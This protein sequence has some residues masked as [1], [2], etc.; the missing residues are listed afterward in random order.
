MLAT[1]TCLA[2]ALHD[3]DTLRCA[4]GERIR[5]A[6]IGATEMD[7]RPRSDQPG[8]AGD[9]YRQRRQMAETAIGAGIGADGRGTTLWFVAPVRLSCRP[10]SI[11]YG[12]V[13]AWC[14]RPDGRDLS[15]AAIAAD[16]ARRWPRYDPAGRLRACLP[17]RRS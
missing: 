6:G 15:C 10:V 2:I 4:S 5:L 8:V 17:R 12:R 13:V 11:S 7:G 3:V 16:V 9:P 1:L 14:A